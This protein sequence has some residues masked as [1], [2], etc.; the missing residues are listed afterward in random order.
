MSFLNPEQNI[1]TGYFG[2]IPNPCTKIPPKGRGNGRKTSRKKR[3]R[4]RIILQR[5]LFV[6]LG[7]AETVSV[8]LY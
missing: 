3:I 1:C 8:D 7:I 6:P 5:F 4:S 2:T